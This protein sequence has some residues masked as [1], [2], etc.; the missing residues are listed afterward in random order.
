[1]PG[2]AEYSFELPCAPVLSLAGVWVSRHKN[3]KNFW[4]EYHYDVID[5]FIFLTTAN[6]NVIYSAISH[7]SDLFMK[8]INDEKNVE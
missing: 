1:M 4:N 8:Y 7:K 5:L 3:Y 6:R 2:L